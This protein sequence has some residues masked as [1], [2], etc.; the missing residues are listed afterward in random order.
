MNIVFFGQGHAVAFS[1]SN[2]QSDVIVA[3]SAI[4]DARWVLRRGSGR[5]STVESPIPWNNVTIWG[6]VKTDAWAKIHIGTWSGE[7][8]YCTIA[9]TE[10]NVI[11][12]NPF[13]ISNG[14]ILEIGT[15]TIFG[16]NKSVSTTFDRTV[17]VTNLVGT[18]NRILVIVV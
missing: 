6:I 1:I 11:P 8:R 10:L 17:E 2:S 15:V 3:S 5:R 16:E 18:H 12:F 7:V 13:T 9:W 4:D 14:N